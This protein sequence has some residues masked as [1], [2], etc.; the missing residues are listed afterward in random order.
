MKIET[1][2]H[3]LVSEK[4]MKIG[5]VTSSGR[6]CQ[7]WGH[8]EKWCLATADLPREAVDPLTKVEASEDLGV[9]HS[10]AG[11]FRGPQAQGLGQSPQ[12]QPWP[13]W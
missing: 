11:A 4:M 12:P 9:G 13:A 1:C 10:S 5:D 8:D 6:K 3:M 2:P 7:C